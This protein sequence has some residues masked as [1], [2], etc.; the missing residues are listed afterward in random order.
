MF[1]EPENA[2]ALACHGRGIDTPLIL[3]ST[4]TD[5]AIGLKQVPGCC[6]QQHH[7]GVG[8]SGGVRVG[9]IG[10]HDAPAPGGVQID[11][12]IARANGTD[13]LELR[14]QCHLVAAQPTAAVRQHGPDGI[15]GLAHGVCPGCILFP[16]A[17]GVPGSGQRGHAFRSDSHQSQDTDSHD[18][19]FRRA[20][21]QLCT[22]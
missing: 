19:S 5:E 3:P 13:D 8:D 6:H 14:K 2:Q 20:P 22:W 16:L 7:R 4:G 21:D 11:R 17:D 1:A 18:R 10:D 9:A 12:F 15:G